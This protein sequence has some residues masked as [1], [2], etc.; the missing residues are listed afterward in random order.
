MGDVDLG[1]PT[2]QYQ[3]ATDGRSADRGEYVRH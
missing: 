1:N 2:H 3:H